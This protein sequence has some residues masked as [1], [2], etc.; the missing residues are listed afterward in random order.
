MWITD[1]DSLY[2][3]D[4]Y[5]IS[6]HEDRIAN[7]KYQMGRWYRLAHKIIRRDIDQRIQR[8]LLQNEISKQRC[9][10]QQDRRQD[11]RSILENPTDRNNENLHHKLPPKKKQFLTA[12]QTLIF[13]RSHLRTDNVDAHI[14]SIGQKVEKCPRT[15]QCSLHQN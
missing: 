6:L 2:W 4:P 14:C 15:D 10:P 3:C 9:S 8:F 5:N 1:L 12:K 11:I 13:H 7:W